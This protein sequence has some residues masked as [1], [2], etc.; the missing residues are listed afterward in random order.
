MFVYYLEHS[1][2]MLK[3]FAE[4]LLKNRPISISR[5]TLRKYWCRTN[6]EIYIGMSEML[7]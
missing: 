6:L 5:Q 3:K 1:V 7:S 2:F 4:K